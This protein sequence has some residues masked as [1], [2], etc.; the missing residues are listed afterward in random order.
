[1]DGGG[2]FSF[3]IN[4]AAVLGVYADHMQTSNPACAQAR[5]WLLD[6]KVRPYIILK[7]TLLIVLFLFTSEVPHFYCAC[8]YNCCPF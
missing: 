4:D 5:I 7:I 2:G 1:M 8:A 6:D 3:L